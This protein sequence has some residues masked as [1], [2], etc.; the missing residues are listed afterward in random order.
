MRKFAVITLLFMVAEFA[1]AQIPT[2]GNIFFGYSYYNTN[3]SGNRKSLNGWE[4]SLEGKFLPFIGIVADFDGHYGS[5]DFRACNGFDC[6][7][8]SADVTHHDYLFGP[9]ASFSVGRFR[10]FG[11]LLIGASHVNAH[12]AT[13][14][15][16]FATAVGGGLD[17]KLLKVLAWR[18]QGDYVHSNLF[19]QPENN[20][21]LSTGIV[22]RF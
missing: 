16:S 19:N 1:A 14:D 9:R 7:L 12:H 6:V 22:L 5:E 17:Y 18:F 15:T 10:P 4:G 11:E 13:S 21:R 2:S 3:L 8:F 20:L